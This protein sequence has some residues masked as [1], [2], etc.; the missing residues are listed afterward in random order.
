[1]EVPDLALARTQHAAYCDAL[2]ALG[3]RLIEL[4]PDAA[5]PDA[6]F[7][8][9]TAIVTARGAVITRPGAESRRGEVATVEAALAPEFERM[10]QV[11]APRTLDGGDVCQIGGHFLIGVS[12]RTNEAG[13]RQL[14]RHLAALGFS[15]ERVDIRHHPELLHLKSGLSWLDGDTVVATRALA[16]HPALAPYRTLVAD[17]GE[18]YAANCV[19]VNDAVLIPAGYPKLTEA[20]ARL[21]LRTIAL[22]MSEF[23]KMDGGL[24]CL[25]LRF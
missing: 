19:R 1:L 21:G 7:V 18:A 2:R 16:G 15:A 11:E 3:L 24:S 10:L 25:S 14:E 12:H 8:E 17:P 22:E 4:G 6:P 5:H 13:A 20:I 9:D 23:R